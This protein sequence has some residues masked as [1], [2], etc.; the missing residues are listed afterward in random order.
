MRA[1]AAALAAGAVVLCACTTL[2]APP[3]NAPPVPPRPSPGGICHAQGA[4]ALVGRTY[5]AALGEELR[6]VTG[7]ERVRVVRPGQVVTMEFDERRLSVELDAR[8]RVASIRC[9]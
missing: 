3:L 7:A 6:R 8:E 1:R 5:D 2:Q 9:G 4:Q